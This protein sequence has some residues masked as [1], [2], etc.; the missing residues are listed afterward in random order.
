MA[1][2][3]RFVL[4]AA[5]LSTGVLGTERVAAQPEEGVGRPSLKALRV[6]T[7]PILDGVIDGDPA[8]SAAER[9]SGLRQ[10]APDEGE[11]ASQ[12]TQIAVVFTAEALYLGVV[13]HDREPGRIIVADARRDSSLED[14]DSIQVVFDT[15]RDR[16][17]GFL[18]GTSPAGNQYDGQ[19]TREGSGSFGSGD[20]LNLNWDGVWEV[21]T[22]LTETGWSAELE[23]PFTTLR[24]PKEEDQTWGFNLQRNIRRRNEVSF[25]APLPLQFD[26][27]RL[28][29]AGS[30][31]GVEVPDQRNLQLVPYVTAESRRA[32]VQGAKTGDDEDYGFDLKYSITPSLTLDATYNTDFAQVEVD[33]QQINLD[34]FN[35]FFPEK[36]PFFLENAGLFQVGASQEIELFFSRR[37]GIGP[38]GEAIPIDG[39]LRLTGKVG[40]FNVGLLHMRADQVI[41]VAPRND[42][43]VARLSRDLPNRSA[44]GALSDPALRIAALRHDIERAVESREVRRGD[45]ANSDAFKAAHARN[46]AAM[47]GG[48]L[49]DC[50]VGDEALSREVHDLVCLHEVGGD[51]RSDRLGDADSLSTFDVNLPLYFERHGWEETHRRCVWGYLRLSERARSVASD[52]PTRATR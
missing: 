17:T 41:G 23:I 22:T 18:F 33:E 35:L 8:W 7:P 37:I 31:V 52:L 6:E 46:S 4:L 48:I 1:P 47:L 9:G 30:L 15:Y 2:L 44:V 39:G 12:V 10:V 20:A 40:A 50:G 14:T 28:S 32:G 51:L 45:F 3:R 13:C 36:R 11:P 42:F 25:W 5:A 24:F 26:L 43:S 49:R 19:V 38:G 34:R 16:R 21:A 27:L 29:M